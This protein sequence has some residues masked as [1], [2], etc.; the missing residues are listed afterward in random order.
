MPCVAAVVR[1]GSAAGQSVSAATAEASPGAPSVA[2]LPAA[3]VDSAAAIEVDSVASAV[4]TG[5]ATAVV[6]VGAVSRN[7]TWFRNVGRVAS[8]PGPGLVPPMGYNVVY[9][10]RLAG[11]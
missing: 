6:I 1:A 2:D 11:H 8:S 10:T 4:A 7:Q 9:A 3:S 5:A